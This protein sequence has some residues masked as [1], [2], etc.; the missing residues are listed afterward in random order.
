M[1][2]PADCN[3]YICIN[4]LLRVNGSE[5]FLSTLR[6][7]YIDPLEKMYQKIPEDKIDHVGGKLFSTTM[8]FMEDLVNGLRDYFAVL[9]LDQKG[10]SLSDNLPRRL[11]YGYERRGGIDENSKLNRDWAKARMIDHVIKLE[12]KHNEATNLL[13]SFKSE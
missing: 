7:L 6:G 11:Y 3:N 4:F 2:I 8:L 10:L 5:A 1:K 9:E 12:E 13:D